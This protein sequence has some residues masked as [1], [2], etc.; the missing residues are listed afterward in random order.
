MQAP[1][2]VIE[3][4]YRCKE[5]V[6]LQRFVESLLYLFRLLRVGSVVAQKLEL[7]PDSYLKFGGTTGGSL[8]NVVAYKYKFAHADVASYQQ[9]MQ[10]LLPLLPKPFPPS[11]DGSDPVAI[12]LQRYQDAL[13]Q[14]AA[15]TP[16]LP[17]RSLRG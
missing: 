15:M 2:A 5:G 12:S 6:E 10:K 3:L 1:A 9:F 16:G 13:L 8:R 4:T 14:S 11:N 17:R 7:K